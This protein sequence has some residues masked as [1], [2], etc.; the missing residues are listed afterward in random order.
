MRAHLQKCRDL[1][2]LGSQYSVYYQLEGSSEISEK[3][4]E[5]I[6]STWRSEAQGTRLV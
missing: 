4:A 6:M 1:E 3:D 2:S 5:F